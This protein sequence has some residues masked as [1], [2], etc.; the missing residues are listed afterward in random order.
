MRPSSGDTC[1][2]QWAGTITIENLERTKSGGISSS[3]S[4]GH[5]RASRKAIQTGLLVCGA[6]RREVFPP[7]GARAPWCA[8]SSTRRRRRTAGPDGARRQAALFRDLASRSAPP[9]PRAAACPE[10]LIN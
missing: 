2:P 4:G 7:A 6:D 8:T 5:L 9:L 10:G 1:S 3:C